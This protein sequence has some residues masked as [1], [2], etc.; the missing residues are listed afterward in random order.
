MKKYI[1]KLL[2]SFISVAFIIGVVNSVYANDIK[3]VDINKDELKKYLSDTDNIKAEE[4]V[5]MYTELSEKYSNKEIAN[6]I[7]E[8]KEEI[9]SKTGIEE[10]TLDNGTK[11]LKTLDT[12]ETRKILKEDLNIEEVQ[13]KL[14]E[15]YS[16][17]EI[18]KEMEEQMPTSKKV[19]IAVSLLLA[20]SI[21][22]IFLLTVMFISCYKII[23]RWIMFKK[24]G[25]HGWASIIPIYKE[26][27]YLKVCGISPWWILILIIPIFGWIIYA[28]VKFIARFTLA[29]A[30]DKGVGFGIGLLLLGIIFESIIAFNKNIKYVGYE[31]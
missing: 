6:M 5:T 7:E 23:V 24:A 10:K 14:D 12:E 9:I 25:R 17:N 20:S 18:V 1:K 30:F 19:N 16:I 8:N 2:I 13:Q 29:E 26:I 27:T 21:V 11:T 31:E 15:G 4:I 22:K 28:I 3:T